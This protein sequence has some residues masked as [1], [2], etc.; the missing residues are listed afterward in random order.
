M[1]KQ[2]QSKEKQEVIQPKPSKFRLVAKRS[3]AGLGLYTLDFIKKGEQ[4][5]QY[6]GYKITN[7]EADRVGGKY[8]FEILK[9]KFTIN[10]TPRWN[11]ARYANH[12]CKP[13]A[14]AVWYGQKVFICSR[15]NIQPGEEITYN[16]GRVYFTDIIGG[17]KK[18]RCAV[19]HPQKGHLG[20]LTDAEMKKFSRK[21][22]RGVS[23]Q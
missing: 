10:G 13:N 3:S 16:Y 20:K 22:G 14:E 9:S 21:A 12:A 23:K 15:K 2:T 5:I 11:L 17:E 6:G 18:C 7:E 19:H 4:I 8:L 1:K